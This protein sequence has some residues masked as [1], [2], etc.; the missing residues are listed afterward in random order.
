MGVTVC[1]NGL[2]VVHKGSGGEAN[3]TLPDVC[4]T[5]MGNSVVP[6]PYGNNAKSADLADGTTTVSMDG[7]NSIAIEGS[8][9]SASTG[10]A[11][12]DKKG[13]SSGTI[14]A[15]A[16]FISSSPTVIIEGK[17]VCRLSDQMTMNKANTMCLGG[18][19]NPAV[20]V[21]EEQE[22][23]YSVDLTC[24]YPNGKPYANADFQLV[25]PSGAMVGAGCLDQQGMA[26]VS[27]LPRTECKLVLKET[28]DRY[29]PNS[30]LPERA[31]TE[32]YPDSHDFCTFVAGSRAPFWDSRVGVAND[33]GILMSPSFSDDDFQSMVYEQSRILSPYAIDRNHSHSFSAAFISA[34]Y[35]AQH[36]TESLEKYEPLL[37]L[38]FEK[39]H[40]N[41]DI[42]RILYQADLLDPPADMLAKLRLL[43]TGNTVQYMQ[44]IMWTFINQQVCGFI[45]ELVAALDERLAYI[46]SQAEAQSYTAVQQGVKGYQSALLTLSRVL[47][48]VFSQILESTN[49]KLL[50]ISGM[51]MGTIVNSNG[52][53]GFST[54]NSEFNAVVYTRT[55]NL[56]RP[57]FIT[58]D[59]V[60]SD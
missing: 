19:Q 50:T 47:P 58:F 4:L 31:P 3:A 27:G 45:D 10:D 28:Q 21:T 13:I 26:T 39:V 56:N 20:S 17:G 41:G 46:Y 23:T 54:T 5:T 6:I 35:H 2:S 14:E 32:T 60:F 34:L 37:E 43:G 59:D 7:G 22:G 36:D 25:E 52:S 44:M 51:A 1:A 55:H 57:P 15:E 11:G 38:L 18:V 49:D 48:D 40:E 24:K 33:W 29:E 30:V 9:F 8:K 16:E 53:S 12:G 42:L